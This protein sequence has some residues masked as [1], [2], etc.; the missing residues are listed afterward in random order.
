MINEDKE[1]TL[2]KN[3]ILPLEYQGK[4]W[5]QISLELLLFD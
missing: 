5:L 3:K 1:G 4:W 2:L